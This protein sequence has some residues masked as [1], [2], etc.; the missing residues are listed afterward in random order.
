MDCL[1]AD[2]FVVVDVV[3]KAAAA[4]VVVVAAGAAGVEL[5]IGC[6][7]LVNYSVHVNSVHAVDVLNAIDFV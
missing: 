7:T 3:D 1:D 2:D 5:V 4:V 6:R